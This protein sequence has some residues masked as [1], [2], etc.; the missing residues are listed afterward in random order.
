MACRHCRVES[1]TRC[2]SRT[3]QSPTLWGTQNPDAGWVAQQ[4]RNLVWELEERGELGV[5]VPDQEPGPGLVADPQ[6][7]AGT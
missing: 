1:L 7:P 6:P 5:V 4:A 3:R 2:R